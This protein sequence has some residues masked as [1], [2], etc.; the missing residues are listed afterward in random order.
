MPP[1]STPGI[2]KT[3]VCPQNNAPAMS[4]NSSAAKLNGDNIVNLCDD[5]D[6]CLNTSEHTNNMEPNLNGES[7]DLNSMVDRKEN[8]IINK[9][10]KDILEKSIS[11]IK[12]SVLKNSLL[13]SA[14]LSTQLRDKV[15]DN[16]NSSL[17]NGEANKCDNEDINTTISSKPLLKDELVHD[18][19]AYNIT[20]GTINNVDPEC[21]FCG[22][23]NSEEVELKPCQYCSD[24]YYCSQTHYEYHRPESTCYPFII[25]H[26]PGVGR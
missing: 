5:S 2:P 19:D 14:N 3:E 24:V 15:K 7:R 20:G 9:F 18:I 16:V 1:T 12:S 23:K 8:K 21:F 22:V 10:D 25:K 17:Q 4:S 26:A 11:E 6:K 13:S